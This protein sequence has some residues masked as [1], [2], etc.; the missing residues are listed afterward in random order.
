MFCFSDESFCFFPFTF[1]NV[2]AGPMLSIVDGYYPKNVTWSP[3]WIWLCKAYLLNIGKKKINII[4]KQY[5][6]ETEKGCLSHETT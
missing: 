6:E 3:S 5:T 2:H 4:F 1:L